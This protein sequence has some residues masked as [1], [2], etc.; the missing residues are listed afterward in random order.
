MIEAKSQSACRLS[1]KSSSGEFCTVDV[2]PNDIRIGRIYKSPKW[3]YKQLLVG[4]ELF[5][6]HQKEDWRK[7]KIAI[8]DLNEQNLKA[9]LFVLDESKETLQKKEVIDKKNITEEMKAG[10]YT[11]ELK[12]EQIG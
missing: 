1:V 2:R 6:E 8:K 9:I 4:G 3:N 10:D 11:E 7:L 12:I 5:F